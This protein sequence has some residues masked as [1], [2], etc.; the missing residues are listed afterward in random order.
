VQARTENLLVPTID[1]FK[2]SLLALL[3]S[4]IPE[5]INLLLWLLA[6]STCKIVAVVTTQDVE[7]IP[8]YVLKELLPQIRMYAQHINKKT[9]D[10]ARIILK[11]IKDSEFLNVYENNE[12]WIKS[13]SVTSQI[14]ETITKL[15]VG[16][17][18]LF[19]LLSPD[20]KI[21]HIQREL[22][23]LDIKSASVLAIMESLS[24]VRAEVE[25]ARKQGIEITNSLKIQ[26]IEL[27]SAK[28][29]VIETNNK[30]ITKN[31]VFIS[32]C[33]ANKR[34][35]KNIYNSLSERGFGCWFDESTMQGG[36]QL[37]GEIDNGISDSKVFIACCSNNYGSSVNCKREVN[38][39]SDR[40]KLIIPILVATCDPW[41]PKG[42]MGP[43]LAG[44]IYIDLSNEENFNKNIEQL[45]AA[46]NQTL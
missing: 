34:Q 40:K 4:T 9:R 8:N 44:K 2:K 30:K 37:F 26:E 18:E 32:Y 10:L 39:A 17:I 22:Q 3:E 12:M 27:Y 25:I 46:I 41:P 45:I 1:A 6:R 11:N 19:R 5:V 33:W 23:R 24:I 29:D 38:L 20:I 7:A 43:L 13:L 15:R 28:K 21:S 16:E 36:S 42:E 35:V 14:S 31:P